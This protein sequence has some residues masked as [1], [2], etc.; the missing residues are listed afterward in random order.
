MKEP[1]TIIPGSRFWKNF[2]DGVADALI[3]GREAIRVTQA[4]G[5]KDGYE[6]GMT[7][8]ERLNN[9]DKEDA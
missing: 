2:K 7:L 1:I 5:Y 6:F 4:E 8:H 9:A 3:I